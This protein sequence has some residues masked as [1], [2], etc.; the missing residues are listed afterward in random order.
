MNS[1]LN[2]A[3][4]VEAFTEHILDLEQEPEFYRSEPQY[5]VDDDGK[6]QVKVAIGNVPL[7]YDLWEGL[8]NPSLVGMYPAGL[9]EIWEYHA[10]K[11]R[12]TVD[13]SGRKTIFQLPVSFEDARRR[14]ARAVIVSAMLPFSRAITREYM[15]VVQGKKRGG[16][17]IFSTMYG[18]AQRMI[19]KATGR[20]A[21][22]LVNRDTVVVAMDNDNVRGVSTE[23]I[24]ATRQ[25]DSHGPTKGGNYPQKSIAVL[26]GLGQFGICK[27]VMRDE[28]SNGAVQRFIGPIRSI[29]L[30]DQEDPIEDGSGGVVYPTEAWRQFL[31][32]LSDFTDADPAINEHR[33]CRYIGDDDSCLEC[34]RSC[35]WGALANSI[36]TPEGRY[37]DRILSQGHRFWD[38]ELQFDFASCLDERGQMATLF[39][40]WTCGR[41]PAVCI[42]DGYREKEAVEA[43]H[44]KKTELTTSRT[45]M[46]PASA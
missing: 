36:P 22:E 33:F 45:V 30:F 38:G 4:L 17:H 21:M 13:R 19:D 34:V 6:P 35:E 10:S 12:D 29:V 16:P 28:V 24:P 7:D 2:V 42:A 18:S 43:Y 11:K 37:S 46:H 3:S 14:Y 15:D 32:R 44:E 26:M 25:G 8:R 39:S 20:V 9:R 40:E 41:C 31:F 5:A 27:I 1:S 23:A